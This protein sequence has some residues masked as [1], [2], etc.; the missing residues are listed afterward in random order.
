MRKNTSF[1]MLMA[2]LPPSKVLLTEMVLS[3]TSRRTAMRSSTTST[4]VTVEVNFCCLSFRSS[5]LLTM[6]A[7]DEMLSMQPRKTHDM[8]LKPSMWPTALPMRN[9]MASSVKAVMAPVAPTFFSF[10]MLNSRPKANIRNTMPMS[11]H[12]CTLVGSVTTGN[13]LK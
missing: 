7:V 13:H 9:M 1:T 4:A 5:K 11:L 2:S 8:S 10:L 12:T 6:M 3:T